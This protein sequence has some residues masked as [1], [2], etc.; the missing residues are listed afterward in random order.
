MGGLL[1]SELMMGLETLIEAFDG[2]EWVLGRELE[3][4]IQEGTLHHGTGAVVQLIM[5]TL[6]G[7]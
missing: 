2:I 7:T 6:Q 4:L 1:V 5:D 3:R